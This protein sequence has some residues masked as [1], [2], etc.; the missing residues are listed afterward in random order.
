MGELVEATAKALAAAKSHL[1][2]MDDGAVEALL[3]LAKKIDEDE[4]RWEICAAWA[5]QQKLKPPPMDNVSLP[6][7]L[8]Y[9]EALGLTP[10]GRTKLGSAK[11]AEGGKLAQLRS[12]AKPA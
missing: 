1:T 5:E 4:A 12:V 2:P 7:Y 8:R 6:T 11:G 3:T 9:C 10:A